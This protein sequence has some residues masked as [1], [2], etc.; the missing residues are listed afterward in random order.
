[1][2]FRRM[3]KNVP[4]ADVVITNPTHYAVALRYDAMT[5]N[6]PQLV[7]KGVDNLALRIREVAAENEVPIVENRQLARTIYSVVEID[8]YIPGSLF[9]AVAEILAYVY[10]LRGRT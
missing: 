5:M 7:A 9:A 8:E 1:M 6:A 4:M 10:R 2:A 3:M